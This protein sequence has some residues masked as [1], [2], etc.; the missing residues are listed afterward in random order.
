MTTKRQK[1]GKKKMTRGGPECFL[2]KLYERW[3]SQLYARRV[4]LAMKKRRKRDDDSKEW[5]AEIEKANLH[6]E[7]EMTRR[8]KKKKKD[9]EGKKETK[10]RKT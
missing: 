6:W 3:M 8:R 5:D 1:K 10:K 9:D 2:R 7:K 4:S